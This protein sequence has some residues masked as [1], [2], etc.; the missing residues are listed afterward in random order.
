MK[1]V[2]ILNDIP[3]DDGLVA[4]VLFSTASDTTEHAE[5]PALRLRLNREQKELLV[6]A[7]DHVI[8]PLHQTAA[9]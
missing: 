3:D 2:P 5:V 7:F 8:V 4:L 9:K 6:D 1:A